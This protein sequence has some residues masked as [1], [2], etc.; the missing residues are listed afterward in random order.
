MTDKA[1]MKLLDSQSGVGTKARR[2]LE[3]GRGDGPNPEQLASLAARLPLPGS[4]FGPG[5]G[6]ADPGSGPAPSGGPGG[7]SASGGPSAAGAGAA[8]AAK[9]LGTKA[10]TAMIVGA[11]LVAGGGGLMLFDYASDPEPEERPS[12]PA[13]IEHPE[14]SLTVHSDEG[15]PPEEP[16][17]APRLE[18]P[19]EPRP[20]QELE[21][22]VTATTAPRR[23]SP[24][25]DRNE[26]SE[27]QSPTEAEAADSRGMSEVE[28]I[29]EAQTALASSPTKALGLARTHASRFPNG[30]L[31]QERE[32]LAIDAL[33]RMG[34]ADAA[35]R[36]AD[37]FR[38]RWPASSH[39]RRVDVL[40]G[41][42]EQA[43]DEE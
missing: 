40:I 17:P 10:V 35:Q 32:V 3:S 11:A 33:V 39:V 21:P 24:S 6:G 34:R 28:L 7:A 1:P 9:A 14:E 12:L 13:T 2:V 29:R 16:P 31:A 26:T 22:S 8:G 30:R 20:L 42:L 38:S 4:P 25:S 18:P 41:R 37:A 36:R 43:N 27:A 23:P 15:V 19:E 5:D